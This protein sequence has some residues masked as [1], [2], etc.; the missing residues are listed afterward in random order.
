MGWSLSPAGTLRKRWDVLRGCRHPSY[1]SKGQSAL[2]CDLNFFQPES[3]GFTKNW[4]IREVSVWIFS[5]I[6]REG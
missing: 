2:H 1:N 3:Q 6:V 4:Q 5:G